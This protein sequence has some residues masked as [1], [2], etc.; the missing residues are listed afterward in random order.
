MIDPIIVSMIV[1]LAMAVLCLAKPNAGRIFL[2]FFYLAMAGI[3]VILALSSPQS[4]IEMG[5][6][7]LIPLYRELFLQVV[8]LNPALFVLP[9]AAFQ[10]AMGLLILGKQRYVKVGLIG[11]I[12]FMI[13]ITPLGIIQLPWLGMV[14]VQAFLLTKEFDKTFLEILRSK[15]SP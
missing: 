1:A 2:G 8:A 9:I 12:I 13:A 3:N 11:T 10:I 5:E 15:P 14:L 4:Y 7:S 6:N